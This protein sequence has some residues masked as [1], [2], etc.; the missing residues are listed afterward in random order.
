MEEE[1]TIEDLKKGKNTYRVVFYMTEGGSVMVKA[2]S[3]ED[4][5]RKV[6][7]Y[8]RMYSKDA[9]MDKEC[10]FDCSNREWDVLESEKI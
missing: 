7:E 3:K 1:I 8:L 10:D 5:E 6:D 2:D 4:A 9:T